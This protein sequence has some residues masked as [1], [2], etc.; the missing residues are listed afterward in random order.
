MKVLSSRSSGGL[1]S[2]SNAHAPMPSTA[3]SH[4]GSAYELQP[5]AVDELDD[6]AAW[7]SLFIFTK[8]KHATTIA[9]CLGSTL[10]SALLRPIAAI[11]FG[12]IFSLLT[13]FGTG[14]LSGEATLRGV[15]TWCTALVGLAGLTWITEFGFLSSWITFGELQARSVREEMFEGMVDKEME[16][17]DL[18]QDGIGSLLIRIQT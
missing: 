7:R 9:L 6:K 13:S 10:V 14:S 5:V 11:F 2:I 12:K 4:D 18:R 8:R 1:E 15:G 17:Y 3:Q 16:W